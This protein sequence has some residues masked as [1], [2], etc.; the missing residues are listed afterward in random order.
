MADVLS[1]QETHLGPSDSP[2]PLLPCGL[3]V[4]A[5]A[6]TTACS[7]KGGVAIAVRHDA[8]ADVVQLPTLPSVDAC[9][10][11]IHV[12]GPHSVTIVSVYVV[13]GCVDPASQLTTVWRCLPRE[14]PIIW[15][16]DFNP[17]G[18]PYEDFV[19]EVGA[20]EANDA[21][22]VTYISG[23]HRTCPDRI[24]C[25]P[26]DKWAPLILDDEDPD[27]LGKDTNLYN[28][29]YP[30]RP[31]PSPMVS[32]HRA[33][34]WKLST[35]PTWSD[36]PA[37]EWFTKLPFLDEDDW[38]ILDGELAEAIPRN[39]TLS[40][41]REAEQLYTRTL[42]A[43]QTT[44]RSCTKRVRAQRAH[45]PSTNRA[46][47]A[48]LQC[49]LTAKQFMDA[50]TPPTGL[51]ADEQRCL[52]QAKQER[53]TGVNSRLR[54]C[55][56]PP[57]PMP[58]ERN[59]YTP[60]AYRLKADNCPFSGL[61]DWVSQ[62]I[63]V[64]SL[65]GI[66]SRHCPPYAN[67]DVRPARP[68]SLSLLAECTDSIEDLNDQFARASS[69]EGAYCIATDGAATDIAQTAVAA[70]GFILFHHGA[71]RQ[72]DVRLLG[73]GRGAYDAEVAAL[74]MAFTRACA[75]PQAS[76]IWILTD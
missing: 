9:A 73:T 47:S 52:R 64:R 13:P 68:T 18:W 56:K 7:R 32:D 11:V 20:V 27:M 41:H 24:L 30:A 59:V 28:A 71:V 65:S 43:V 8:C 44:I 5:T 48:L 76:A 49:P 74:Q 38:E 45:P 63:L 70:A 4:V 62:G 54:I 1:I 25:C 23:N 50:E 69:D 46:T 57:P 17:T 3:T 67:R 61:T 19:D 55:P 21:S 53:A 22:A 40:S 75:L 6:N 51:G 60:N 10:A 35:P 37:N 26:T 36:E 33:I 39:L 72:A 16:G 2:T 14:H 31:V 42:R 12:G 34:L 15:A 58:D 29:M 66:S